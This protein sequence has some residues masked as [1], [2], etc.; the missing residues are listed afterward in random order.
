[1]RRSREITMVAF[2]P[3]PI[4]FALLGVFN[5]QTTAPE[6][7]VIVF[8]SC[9]RQDKPALAWGAM[10]AMKP[11]LSVLLGDNIYGDT[12]DMEVLKAKYSL[13][14]KV[15]GFKALREACP[16]MAV[17]DDHDYGVNDGGASYPQREASR[18]ILLDFFGEPQSSLRRTQSGGI[19][20]SRIFGPDGRRI[21]VIL[22]DTRYERSALKKAPGGPSA[23]YLP[24]STSAAVMLAESQWKW[25]EGEL[26]Q[27]A[28]I[29][30]IGSSI[31]VVSEDHRFEKWANMPLERER[32]FKTIRASGASGVIVMSG[33]RHLGDISSMD[34][35]LGFPLIDITASGINQA[36]QAYRQAEPNRH[37]I[38]GMPWGNHFGAVRVSW[39]TNDPLVSLELRDETGDLVVSHRVPLSALRPKSKMAEAN[40]VKLAEG[41]ITPAV[42]REM[43]GKKVIVRFRVESTGKAKD[44]SRFFLNSQK[45]FRSPENLTVVVEMAKLSDGLKA[46]GLKDVQADFEGKVVRVSGM[47][48]LFRDSPQII[49]DSAGDISLEP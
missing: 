13:L 16:M 24:D 5:W 30:L 26:K 39:S 49:L 47:L 27:P 35:G 40:N 29:R 38:A 10:A 11:Q 46:K 41:E 34:A 9:A 12:V 17:W 22:L 23:G 4:V 44:G 37:R 15:S 6:N 7:T 19:F 20:T 48:T 28:E 42:A 31:Q 21:Q 3:F 36:S 2:Q 1:M 18:K 43:V 33:D 8:A 45:D 32:L 14:S 25:L